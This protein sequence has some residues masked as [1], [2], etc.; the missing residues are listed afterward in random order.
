MA[1]VKSGLGVGLS[2]KFA[3][4]VYTQQPDGSTSASEPATPTT[5]PLSL[6]QLS[7]LMDTCISSAF[8]K[9][10]PYFIKVGF[11]L[12]TSPGKNA[13]N[14]AVPYLRKNA[15]TGVYP[16]RRI[17]YAKVLLTRGKMPS[18]KNATVTVN[19]LGFSFT[20]DTS[21]EDPRTHYS[22]QVM[23][24]AYFT[25]IKEAVYV[26]GGAQRGRGADLLV[27]NGIKRGTTAEIYISFIADD[28]TSISNSVHLGQV[29]W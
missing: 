22:D 24:M 2:G 18:P 26:T 5:K 25:K 10:I 19:E 3:G 1:K 11:G 13:N 4:I 14:I 6:A 17:D 23:L 8:V 15:L 21:V 29:N 9:P 28:R 16:D 12:E 7:I 27:P 20:W